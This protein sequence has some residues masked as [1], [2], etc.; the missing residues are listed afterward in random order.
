MLARRVF[1]YLLLLG[2]SVKKKDVAAT[3]IAVLL[4]VFM[5]VGY[6]FVYIL[7][8][9]DLTWHLD[10]SLN[11][12]LLQVW[13]LAIFAYFAIVRAPEQAVMTHMDSPR[14]QEPRDS[15]AFDPSSKTERSEFDASLAERGNL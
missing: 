9:F 5:M 3:S 6:L 13:P 14:T 4:P 12:L 7:S 2:V 15:G 11:R 8:P 1:F 10:S